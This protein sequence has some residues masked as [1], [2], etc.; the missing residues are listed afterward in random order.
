[1]RFNQ[2]VGVIAPNNDYLNVSINPESRFLISNKTSNQLT[3]VN[4]NDF[5]G[6]LNLTKLQS[7]VTEKRSENTNNFDSTP[8][9]NKTTTLAN[10]LKFKSDCKYFKSFLDSQQ[11]DTNNI[12]LE[13]GNNGVVFIEALNFSADCLSQVSSLILFPL[14]LPEKT[15]FI[16]IVDKLESWAFQARF[17]RR[18]TY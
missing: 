5:T 15:Q 16:F 6:N 12:D 9:L 1:M 3:R 13:N 7:I 17:S 14:S 8:D 11:T 4:G 2:P 18:T 10:I